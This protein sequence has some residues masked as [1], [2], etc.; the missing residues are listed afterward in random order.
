MELNVDR[1]ICSTAMQDVSALLTIP[2]NFYN[3]IT[4][5]P[6]NP[7]NPNPKKPNF[8]LIICIDQSTAMS[9]F[10][11]LTSQT[12]EKIEQL[13]TATTPTDTVSVM[14]FNDSVNIA[15]TPTPMDPAGKALAINSLSTFRPS[16]GTDLCEVLMQ[17]LSQISLHPQLSLTPRQSRVVLFSGSVPTLGVTDVS[18][19]MS[20]I[21]EV[22][23]TMPVNLM[24]CTTFFTLGVGKN[25]CVELLEFLSTLKNRSV[26]DVSNSH[27]HSCSRS[28][29]GYNYIYLNEFS[30][31]H[32]LF[33]E[34]CINGFLAM[35]IREVTV[36]FHCSENCEIKSLHG[37]GT[38]TGTE[39]GNGN[40]SKNEDS[41]CEGSPKLFLHDMHLINATEILFHVILFGGTE[42][43]TIKCMISTSDVLLQ[44]E[45][46]LTI[47]RSSSQIEDPPDHNQHL[48]QQRIEILIAM[49]HCS[50]L[51]SQEESKPQLE[52]AQLVLQRQVEKLQAILLELRGM[53]EEYFSMEEEEEEFDDSDEEEVEDENPYEDSWNV[54]QALLLRAEVLQVRFNFATRKKKLLQQQTVM[55][56]RKKKNLFKSHTFGKKTPPS[57]TPPAPP[58]QLLGSGTYQ[59]LNEIGRGS[60]GVI[61]QAAKY[62]SN[63]NKTTTVA[64]KHVK[65]IFA[66]AYLALQTLRE[67]QLLF[68]LQKHKNIVEIQ[69]VLCDGDS[70]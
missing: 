5:P 8:D 48:Q 62:N 36:E 19:I 57:T 17:A 13:I 28:S 42:D 3:A 12:L 50:K 56:S 18:L 67:I 68:H 58:T 25:H 23:N 65:N 64:I 29:S 66:N 51:F 31:N 44:S 34:N 55:I 11:S 47:T 9:A 63:P 30:L 15:L 70:R 59:L 46:V 26:D 45:E 4:L 41:C 24:A 27:S 54:F 22:M 69:R 49:E 10:P 38:G 33:W 14:F 40:G 39:N 1:I 32:P 20:S 6:S 52:A 43:A 7:P 21:Q 37:F 2:S 61:Y 16:G 53:M 35:P 60:Y